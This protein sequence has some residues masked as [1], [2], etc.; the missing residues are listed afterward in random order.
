MLHL[1]PCFTWCGHLVYLLGAKTRTC[2]EKELT[3]VHLPE[4]QQRTMS[5]REWAEMRKD[6]PLNCIMLNVV[7]L[8]LATIKQICQCIVKLIWKNTVVQTTIC[9][10]TN[11]AFWTGCKSQ[12]VSGILCHLVSRNSRSIF[13]GFSNEKYMTEL[14]QWP[15]LLYS[16]ITYA[17]LHNLVFW[18]CIYAFTAHYHKTVI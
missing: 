18:L 12:K 3:S 4:A 8:I 7:I 15:N 17:S 6:K 5:S 14:V 16:C 9:D 2:T 1:Y 11:S 10:K 13:S